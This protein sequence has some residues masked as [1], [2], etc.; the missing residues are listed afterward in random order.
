MQ[1]RGSSDS[2]ATADSH[3]EAQGSRNEVKCH[4]NVSAE[5]SFSLGKRSCGEGL[6]SRWF[7][8]RQNRKTRNYYRNFGLIFFSLFRVGP[9]VVRESDRIRIF[10]TKTAEKE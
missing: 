10:S 2:R 6:M 3:C 9:L 5:M 8:T 7:G 1:H 4:G